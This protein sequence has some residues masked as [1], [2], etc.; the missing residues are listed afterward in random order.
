[1]V[2]IAQFA[3]FFSVLCSLVVACGGED[4]TSGS[5]GAPG[6]GAT[7]GGGAVGSGGGGG[8][9]GGP[10]TGTCPA[11]PSAGLSCTSEDLICTYGTE[12]RPCQR[13]I[14]KCTGG[15]FAQ[16]NLPCAAALKCPSDVESGD[17]CSVAKVCPAWGE[18]CGCD[19]QLSQWA[20]V[21]PGAGCLPVVPNAG[22]SCLTDGQECIYGECKVTDDDE[23]RAKCE[24]GVWTWQRKQC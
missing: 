19:I 17:S 8:S 20:C 24:K 16:M 11:A 2:R 9:A 5:G 1:M 13:A 3:C 23:V 4:F 6:T 15:A 14:W 7:S 10:I 18:L 21:G 22:T 12:P